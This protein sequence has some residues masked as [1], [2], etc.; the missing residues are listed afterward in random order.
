MELPPGV[1]TLRAARTAARSVVD[2]TNMSVVI[3]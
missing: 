1:V 2:Q 3:A